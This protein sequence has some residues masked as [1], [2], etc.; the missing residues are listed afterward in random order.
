MIKSSLLF[1]L[2][3]ATILGCSPK[4]S[5]SRIGEN[6]E[7]TKPLADPEEGDFY[8]NDFLRYEDHV[9]KPYIKT[10]QLYRSDNELSPPIIGLATG[11]KLILSFDELGYEN[12]SYSYT[13]I[14]CDAYW[15]PTDLIESLYIRG[16]NDDKLIDRKS[17]FNTIT[18]YTHY[19]LVFPTK[20]LIPIIS[21]NY[22]IKVFQDF[23]K[24]NIVLT[25]R[26][27]ITDSK[28]E[29]VSNVHRATVVQ[30]KFNKQEVDFTIFHREYR[31]DNPFG[32]LK[33]VI[34]Q[35]DRWD[36]AIKDLKPLFLKDHEL[37][38]DLEDDNLFWG[39]NEFRNFDTRSLR[40][41]TEY[42]ANIS[43]DSSGYDVV[44]R[45]D[46][47]RSSS[48]YLSNPDINGKYLIRKQEGRD[49]DLE[50][51]YTKVHFRLVMKEPII[52]G[53]IYVLG[54]LT[55][56]TYLPEAKMIYDY[57]DQVYKTTLFLKQGY[58]NYE[59]VVLND[60]TGKG[61]PTVIEGSHYETENDYS[62]YIY[63]QGIG[64]AY[65][66]LIGIKRTNSLRNY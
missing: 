24:D 48:V 22:V 15:N 8:R 33:V 2:L 54:A 42:V 57:D 64:V 39:G 14:H 40:F 52:D 38:Y 55:N 31:I 9:Y 35:N 44:L 3:I 26:F 53:N 37:T 34:T 12:R 62:I 58:Y 51:D 49:S 36:N 23:D 7:T 43:Q 10:V 45:N 47:S 63:H 27:M 66:R 28:V 59:Y 20:D 21:G 5:P 61:D 1:C 4:T 17:S 13:L 16:F 56:W 50:S 46:K 41:Q 11:E 6:V 25:K 32:E 19:N 65:D 29:V 60:K 30:Y 18:P